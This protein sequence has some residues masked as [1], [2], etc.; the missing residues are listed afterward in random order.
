MS[1]RRASNG[2]WAGRSLLSSASSTSIPTSQ[3]RSSCSAGRPRVRTRPTRRSGAA[4]AAAV[5][6]GEDEELECQIGFHINLA[7]EDAYAA[8]GDSLDDLDELLLDGVLE[9]LAGIADVVPRAG[10]D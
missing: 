1:T 4:F 8:P 7:E 5:R 9:L 2:S 6:L 3:S 10:D